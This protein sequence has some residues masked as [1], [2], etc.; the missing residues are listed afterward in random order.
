M[1][2]VEADADGEGQPLDGLQNPRKRGDQ[3]QILNEEVGVLEEQQHPQIE[4]HRQDQPEFRPL[5]VALAVLADGKA[6][7]VGH[8]NGKEHDDDVGRL[9]EAVEDHAEEKQHEIPTLQGHDIVDQQ[10]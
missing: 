2:G 9:A 6:R 7:E 4:A 3:S 5:G 10:G 8:G 1:E